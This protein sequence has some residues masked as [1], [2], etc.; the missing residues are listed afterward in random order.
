MN[1]PKCNKT[2]DPDLRF[3]VKCGSP[4]IGPATSNQS[5]SHEDQSAD[6]AGY[7][8][9]QLLD[10]SQVVIR[11]S[12]RVAVLE[13]GGKDGPSTSRPDIVQS[14]TLEPPTSPSS[15][16]SSIDW[17]WI[18]GVNWIA[19]VGA[20]VLAIGVGLFLT[21]N[22]EKEWLG[23]NEQVILGIL[24]G[25]AMLTIG[26]YSHRRVPRWAQSVTGGGLSILYLSIYAAFEFFDIVPL[27]LSVIFLGLVVATGGM[28]AIRYESLVIAIL[29]LIGAFILP[30][31]LGDDAGTKELYVLLAYLL[32]VDAGILGVSMF[33]NWRWFTLVGLLSSY[34]LFLFFTGDIPTDDVLIAQAGLSGIFII[35]AGS[36]TLFHIVWRI[37]PKPQDLALITLNAGAFFIVTANLLWEKYEGWFGLIALMLALFYSILGYISTRR[38]RAPVEV[39]IWLLAAALVFL[40]IVMPL[41]LDG[42]WITVAWVTEATVLTW[43]G[44]TLANWQMRAFALAVFTLG[45]LNLLNMPISKD[46]QSFRLILNARF[47]AFTVSIIAVYIS[48]YFY[49]LNTTRLLPREKFVGWI[50]VGIANL[51]TVWALSTE[52]IRFFDTESATS[53][54]IVETGQQDLENLK[55]LSLTVLWAI[56]ATGVITVGIWR[57]NSY[58]RLAGVLFTAIAVAKLFTYDLATLDLEFKIAAFVILGLLLLGTGLVYQRYSTAVKGF[59]FGTQI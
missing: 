5:D 6:S 38:S 56:Y 35:F 36:T 13:Q 27:T 52:I 14:R 42:S 9:Q 26:E 58:V 21:L 25:L 4:L 20:V 3:C 29:G 11:L 51:L 16:K 57:D 23:N 49:W 1:C 32:V 45:I 8:Q 59:L 37:T 2:N 43:L 40:S 15:K 54:S 7:V 10:L 31:L 44:F 28:L 41:Q 48:S 34:I 53:K 50:L 47:L 33:R 18:L 39:T 24:I 19:I 17:E 22:V 30:V 12:E 55:N 46:Y